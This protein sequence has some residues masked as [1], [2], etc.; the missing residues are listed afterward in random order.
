M[1]TGVFSTEAPIQ[2]LLSLSSRGENIGEQTVRYVVGLARSGQTGRVSELTAD[3]VCIIGQGRNLNVAPLQIFVVGLRAQ[4]VK[5]GV[6]ERPE[7]GMW[8]AT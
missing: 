8:Y 6:V 4:H 5:E 3:V 1:V 2:A 7:V